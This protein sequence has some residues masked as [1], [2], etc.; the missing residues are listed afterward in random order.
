MKKWNLRTIIL[1]RSFAMI[2]LPLWF[3]IYR[4]SLP[5]AFI[6]ILL[7]GLTMLL[8]HKLDDTAKSQM[9]ECAQTL[10]N[11]L[12]QHVE[13]L[14][15][16]LIVMVIVFLT[17]IPKAEAPE[18]MVIL[19]AQI[20]AWGLFGIHLYRGIAFWVRDRMGMIC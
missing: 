9:D 5:G 1:L 4:S 12:T 7:L 20:L 14:T 3:L 6:W 2:V 11:R 8:I 19:A 18:S 15:Y 13:Y 17:Q 10:L 16:V